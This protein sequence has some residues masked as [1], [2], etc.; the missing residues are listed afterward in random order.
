MKEPLLSVCPSLVISD[1][2]HRGLSKLL[3]EITI[4]LFYTNT[5][6]KVS[7]VDRY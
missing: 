3:L 6:E 4:Q 5:T 7:K 2:Q 1:K